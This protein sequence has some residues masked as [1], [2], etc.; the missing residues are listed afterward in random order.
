MVAERGNGP[1][2]KRSRGDRGRESRGVDRNREDEVE[3]EN[4]MGS[5]VDRAARRKHDETEIEIQYQKVDE[6][7]TEVPRTSSRDRTLQCTEEQILDVLVPE[8][9]KQLMEV[10]ET[11]SQDRI[12]QRTVEQIV[13]APVSETVEELADVFKVSS[14]DRIQ[15]YAVEQTIEI[16]AVS[17]DEK[18]IEVPVART[19]E[20]AQQVV[21]TLVQHDVNTVEVERPQIMKQTWQKP[22]IQEKINQ[23]TR[24]VEIPQVQF[25]N[26][27]D[28]MPV[29]VQRQILPM[30]QT[31]QKTTEIPQLQFP[32]QVH[33]GGLV[34]PDD[35]DAQIK[36]LAAETLTF[37]MWEAISIFIQLSAMD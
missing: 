5:S 37:T 32:D 22:I 36:F 18:I 13:D 35:P 23:V 11:D 6:Q 2:Q 30:T 1:R 14:Q 3:I 17:L 25:L 29:G 16:P 26:K 28:E 9:A 8:T 15:Q 7:V 19:P 4:Q 31:V 27:V 34:K 21:N 20:K 24:H 33:P 12:K 10:P